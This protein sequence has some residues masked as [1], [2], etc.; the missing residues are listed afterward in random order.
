[1]R[2]TWIG[3][4]LA[5]A[6]LA[7]LPLA[8]CGSDGNGV[9]TCQQLESARCVYAQKCGLDL[10]FPLHSGS[11]PEDA[12]QA[13]QLF[14]QDACLHGFVTSIN[15]TPTSTMNDVQNCL[16]AINNPKNNCNV[17]LNPQTFPA[18][19]WLNPP[20]SGVDASDALPDTFVV[21]VDTGTVIPDAAI[22]TG[23]QSCIDACDSMCVDNATCQEDCEA[24]CEEG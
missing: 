19:M 9:G 6:V 14:Y 20:D 22:D 17:V 5:A 1:M 16:N 11:S 10:S 15:L 12:V 4:A 3:L 21:V 24:D 13:C 8:A 2:R 18:C 23:I 7:G